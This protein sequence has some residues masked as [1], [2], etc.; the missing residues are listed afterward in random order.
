M[1][2][3]DMQHLGL[4]IGDVVEISGKRKTVGKA[5]PA[6][7]EQR[8]ESRVQIDGLMRENGG[9]GLDQ[10]VEVRKISPRPASRVV[11]APITITPRERDLKYI[12]SLLDGL[13]VI[14]GDRVRAA[15]FGSRSADFEVT[16]TAPVG[17]VMINP[18]TVLEVAKSKSR[19]ND[20]A[21]TLSYEDVGGVRREL[22]RIRE[23]I[24]LPLRYPEVFERLGIDA[25]KGFCYTDRR[26]VARL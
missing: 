9:A 19:N 11:L 5:M 16:S 25:P 20:G 21:H 18:T 4:Q 10:V 17:A 2:P 6:F 15:L 3:A 22:Q 7:K 26:D 23:I 1:D 24:E 8:G 14:S 12:G 13:A